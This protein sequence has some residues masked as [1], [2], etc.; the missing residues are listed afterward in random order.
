MKHPAR[1]IF[2]LFD[3]LAGRVTSFWRD[4]SGN[5]AVEFALI[6]PF[7]ALILT[8]TFDIGAIIREKFT[9]D[10]Q[11]SAAAS[12]GQMTG[13]SVADDGADAYARRV[14][15]ILSDDSTT[16][17]ATVIFNNAL[18]ASLKGGTVS[19]TNSSGEVAQCY[20]PSRTDDTITWGT[21]RTCLTPCGDG[22]KAGRFIE[23]GAS[24]P[25]ISL[26][27]GYGMTRDGTISTTAVVRME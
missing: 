17:E 22:S 24:T 7:F 3:P 11:I 14:V 6:A 2:H 27:G 18:S 13:R 10:A 19:T 16:Q 1:P 23:L 4:R 9:L 15:A 8:A 25:Y 21:A 12:F 5:A 26:F 20:C